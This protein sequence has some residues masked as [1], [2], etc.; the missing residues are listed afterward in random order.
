MI[1]LAYGRWLARSGRPSEGAT[2]L[3]DALEVFERIGAVRWS[4]CARLELDELGGRG[5]AHTG[6]ERKG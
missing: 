4:R 1:Q 6:T 3:K 5:L 2:H